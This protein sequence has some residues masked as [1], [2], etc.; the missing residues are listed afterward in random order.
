MRFLAT[1]PHDVGGPASS[2]AAVMTRLLNHP[3]RRSVSIIMAMLLLSIVLAGAAASPAGAQQRPDDLPPVPGALERELSLPPLRKPDAIDLGGGP[4]LSNPIE[5]PF[6]L[7]GGHIIVEASIDGNPPKPFMFDTGAS[8]V[9]M[10]DIAHALNAPV[11][12]TARVGGIGPKV[13]QVEMIKVGRITIGAAALEHPTAAVLDMPNTLVDRG[14]RPRLAGL[15]GSELLARYAITIDYERHTLTLNNPGFRPQ[16]AAFSLPLGFSISQDGLTHPSISA[17]LDGVAG[18]FIIDT[19]SGGQI[20]VSEK[21]QR[22][23][24]PFANYAKVLSFLSAGGIG[25]RTNVELGFGK[26]LRFGPVSFAPPI[27]VGATD[28]ANPKLGRSSTA[29]TAG[30][31][32]AAI[33]AQFIVTIDY[34]SERAYFEPVAGRKL[35]S[36][37]HGTGMIFDKPDHEAFEVLDVLKDSAAERAGLHRGDRIVEVAGRPARDL[38]VSDVQ[39]LGTAPAH[40]SLTIRTSDPRRLDLAIRQILP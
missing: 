11:A 17:E 19:G 30:V 12:R 37:L 8:I 18:D 23:H 40:T 15:I 16:A 32:G 28:A 34:Q 26:L 27:V 2:S 24:A 38:S 14:S 36:I 9:I 39:S 6:I 22:E 33:L 10:P 25:G 1:M 20:F 21:F 5:I 29:H 31:I 4:S 35:P 7:E 3:F 13:S